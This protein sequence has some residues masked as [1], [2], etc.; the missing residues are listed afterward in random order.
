MAYLK[1]TD[2]KLVNVYT[3]T[4]IRSMT[5]VPIRSTT[6]AIQLSVSDIHACIVAKARIEEILLDASIVPLTFTNYNKDNNEELRNKMNGVTKTPGGIKSSRKKKEE[7]KAEEPAPV[8]EEVAP[9]EAVEEAPAEDVVEETVE[10]TT[11]EAT[12]TEAPAAEGEATE[13]A[14]K[15][16]YGRKKKQ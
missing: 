3:K 12:E 2:T 4:P 11:E 16:K 5:G 8:V 14:P 15:R 10:E 1:P 9:V 7:V 13:P 6:K